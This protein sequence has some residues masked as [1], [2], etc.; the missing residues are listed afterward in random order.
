[1][2]AL[3]PHTDDS[4]FGAG[5]ML[6]R[7]VSEG[8]DVHSVAFSVPRESLPPS[9]GPETLENE[10]REASAILGIPDK[11]LH[12][13]D[14]PVRRL[15]RY[16]QEVLEEMVR[17]QRDLD[18]DL[19]LVHAST[20][21]HQDHQTVQAEAL[22]A[23]KRTTILGYELPWNNIQFQAHALIA[24]EPAHIQKKISAIA[25]YKSQAHRLYSDPEFLEGWARLR[26]VTIGRPLAE[27]FEVIRWVIR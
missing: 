13:F 8:A 2:L 17:M 24:L 20:D 14:F 18:P 26:G 9:Y 11:N 5:G 22:R 27:A 12:L 4:E 16:R 25:A 3:A 6:A 15:P 10:F 1:V 7:L 21:V 19:V 23:F